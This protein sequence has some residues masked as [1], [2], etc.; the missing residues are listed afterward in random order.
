MDILRG[1]TKRAPS[2]PGSAAAATGGSPPTE[3][4]TP[5]DRLLQLSQES[6]VVVIYRRVGRLETWHPS[7]KPLPNECHSLGRIREREDIMYELLYGT[8]TVHEGCRLH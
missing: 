8:S 4:C 7:R 3:E 1:F 2:S 6:G 5:G